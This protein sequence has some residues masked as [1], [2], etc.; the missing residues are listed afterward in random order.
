MKQIYKKKPE[1]LDVVFV[2]DDTSSIKEVFELAGVSNA[3]I[4]FDENGE[5]V[6]NLDE[7]THIKVGMVVFKDK[8]TGKLAC[9]SQEKLLQFYDLSNDVKVEG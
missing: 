9:M 7:N 8:K 3:S 5:R 4:N 2:D 6:I 1:Y